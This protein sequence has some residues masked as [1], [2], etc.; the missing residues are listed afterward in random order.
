MRFVRKMTP[1]YY[2]IKK[3]ALKEPLLIDI[4]EIDFYN[5]DIKKVLPIDG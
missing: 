2:G 3:E 1:T 4:Y 5:D